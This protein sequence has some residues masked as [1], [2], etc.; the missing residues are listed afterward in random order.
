[1][2]HGGTVAERLDREA[3]HHNFAKKLKPQFIDK[4][5]KYVPWPISASRI[6]SLMRWLREGTLR[7]KR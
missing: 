6:A 1:M 5:F 3:F 2:S 4:I 7:P